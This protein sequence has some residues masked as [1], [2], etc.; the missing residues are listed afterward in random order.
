MWFD[1]FGDVSDAL[2]SSMSMKGSEKF[3][4]GMSIILNVILQNA[5]RLFQVA[6]E[7]A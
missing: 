1:L 6:F 4:R 2:A 7:S 5:I 3:D